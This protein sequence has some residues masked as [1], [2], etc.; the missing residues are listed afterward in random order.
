[1]PDH[2]D[3][4]TSWLEDLR[5]EVVHQF[6]TE[7][8]RA[9]TIAELDLPHIVV[10]RD[11]ET[12]SVSYSGPFP[13]GFRALVYAER[14]GAVDCELNDGAPLRFDVAALYPPECAD[15]RGG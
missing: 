8:V 4:E 15:L 9:A 5:A 12:G 7:I 13:D 11:T 1:M 14:E 3:A 10:C 6:L 2:D